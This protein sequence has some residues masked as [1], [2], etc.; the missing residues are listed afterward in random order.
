VTNETK[1]AVLLHADVVDSTQLVRRDERIAHGRIRSAFVEASR[2]ISKYGGVTQELRGDALLAEFGRAS[3]AATAALAIQAE[4]SKRNDA[5]DDA[6][7]PFLRIGISLGEVV[8][9]DNTV[10]GAGVVQAQRLEQLAQPG[11]V[12]ISASVRDAIPDRLPFVYE[13]LGEQHLKGFDEAVRAYLVGL[14]STQFLPEPDTPS[15]KP[16][17]SR[18][19]RHA[20]L[21]GLFLLVSGGGSFLWWIQ[22]SEVTNGSDEST[23]VE[24]VSAASSTTTK[25]NSD[26][27]TPSKET[28]RDKPSIAVLAFDNLS[29]DPEQDYLASGIAEDIITDLSK[30]PGLLVI[31][32]NSSF[33]Y[34]QK[35]LPIQEIATQLGVNYVLEGSVRRI[36]STLRINAQLIDAENDTHAWADRYD[37]SATDT[38]AFQDAIIEKVVAALSQK[39]TTD[40]LSA[41]ADHPE[42][43]P[44]AYDAFLRGLRH[45]HARGSDQLKELE[46]ARRHFQRAI[47]LDPSFARAYAALGWAD[48]SIF[49]EFRPLDTGLSARAFELAEKSIALRD[50][51]LARRVLAKKFFAPEFTHWMR[52]SPKDL[53]GLERGLAELR[54]AVALEPNNP[55]VLAELAYT[56]VFAGRPSEA[57][58]LTGKAKRLNPHFPPWYHRPAGIAQ[59]MLGNYRRAI[60]EFEGWHDSERLP[61]ESTFWLACAYAQSGAVAKGR[62]VF[63]MTLARWV[64]SRPN[65]ESFTSR[66]FFARDADRGRFAEGLGKLGLQ[67]Q[68]AVESTKAKD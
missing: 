12:C 14:Q 35:G 54:R 51:S 49:A 56:L 11:Q 22:Q 65:I 13:N 38:L 33:S 66:Y 53:K 29:N 32:R 18:G 37:G 30:Q 28:I 34:K 25:T 42:A 61:D 62:D 15:G 10:T 5:F 21:L 39:L 43:V 55:D 19:G 48:F 24:P 8:I 59:Y 50:N 57:A 63:K 16:S 4:N 1:L 27:A 7:H 64:Y 40:N 58:E 68:K 17:P 60:P 2:V 52:S 20:A 9:A 47:E 23:G 31:A 26:S 6:I 44:E 45:I 41:P 67:S 46:D 36:G 3:D